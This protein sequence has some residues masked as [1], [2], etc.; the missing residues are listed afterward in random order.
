MWLCLLWATRINYSVSLVLKDC[1]KRALLLDL[2]FY[3]CTICYFFST[4]VLRRR[5]VKWIRS[6][7]H[8]S[9]ARLLAGE[10]KSF[11][12]LFLQC[13]HFGINTILLTILFVIFF[14]HAKC[15]IS[16]SVFQTM[17]F[18]CL[19]SVI[20]RICTFTPPRTS[21]NTEDT[22]WWKLCWFPDWCCRIWT[23]IEMNIL[24]IVVVIFHI[25]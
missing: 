3:L 2:T 20:H 16:N 12:F 18:L 24:Y 14:P 4:T 19:H 10:K 11:I 13:V 23:G 17:I 7:R 21:R 25:L 9:C 5:H 8:H 1:C 6:H 15:N 22:C